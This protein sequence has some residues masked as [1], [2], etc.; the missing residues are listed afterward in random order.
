MNRKWIKI[1]RGKSYE[2]TWCESKQKGRCGIKYYNVFDVSYDGLENALGRSVF[3]KWQL[4]RK[5]G[6]R[7]IRRKHTERSTTQ[8]HSGYTGV[9]NSEPMMYTGGD[10]YR[11]QIPATT[12]TCMSVPSNCH[13]DFSTDR[14]RVKAGEAILNWLYIWKIHQDNSGKNMLLTFNAPTEGQDANT[15][16][17]A[18]LPASSSNTVY[19]D[20]IGA[21]GRDKRHFDDMMMQNRIWYRNHIVSRCLWSMNEWNTIWKYIKYLSSG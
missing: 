20:G 14:Q 18:F 16:S 4:S 3:V 5:R 6:H 17:P 10:G 8:Q 11:W 9:Y 19:L 13:R 2:L 1:K 12:S 7:K 21:N 15:A